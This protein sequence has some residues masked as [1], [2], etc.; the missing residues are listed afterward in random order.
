MKESHYNYFVH[1]DGNVICMN[2][3]SG[4]VFSISEDIYNHLLKRIL[5]FPNKDGNDMDVVRMLYK[6]NFLIDDDKDEIAELRLRY[7]KAMHSTTYHL[8]IN[9]TLECN[10]RCWYCYESHQKGRMN[11][12]TMERVKKFIEETVRRKDISH[13]HLSWFGGEPLL[14]FNEVMYPIAQF[15]QQKAK[16]Y[17]K[18]FEHSM[19]S[20]GYCLS[21]EVIKKSAE[22]NLTGI[23][24]TL[25]GNRELHNKV[26]NCNGMPSYDIIVN[27]IIR[28]CQSNH[29]NKIILRI[30]YTNE[31]IQSNLEEVFQYIPEDI[32]P[33]I[34]AS[35]H[36]VW[37]TIGL[38]KAGTDIVEKVQKIKDLKYSTSHN[39]SYRRYKGEVCYADSSNYANINFDGDV[40]RCTGNDY[41]RENRLGYLNE[42]GR[43]VWEQKELLNKVND[44]SNFENPVC[45]KCKKLAVCG[46]LCFKKKFK[47]ITTG[48]HICSKSQMDTGL[49]VFVK[50]Y[51]LRRVNQ[52]KLLL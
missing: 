28:Y 13:F 51:Y 10:F 39:A 8:I 48:K 29:N 36:R 7:N 46:G 24:V 40:Y 5:S 25:D 41:K 49:D 31:I 22:I 6:L 26:R 4:N 20:N 33:Q 34:T 38:E 35:F 14:Y 27:N 37:Q 3:I 18:T 47:Y 19:T 1:D 43:I 2:G 15:A 9:P 12:D 17:G 42:Q 50:E 52:R 45:L 11:I 44:I 21:E 30:N 16:E 23:Q 32:R